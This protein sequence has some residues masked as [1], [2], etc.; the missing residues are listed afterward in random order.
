MVIADDSVFVFPL[1]LATSLVKFQWLVQILDGVAATTPE[2]VTESFDLNEVGAE[3]EDEL[4][5]PEYDD[6]RQ[7]LNAALAKR[8]SRN[9][10]LDHR[11]YHTAGA[12]E[13]IKVKISLST[14][15]ICNAFNPL[16]QSHF[17]YPAETRCQEQQHP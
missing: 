9:E 11:R 1:L 3:L 8:L 6:H 12:I 7:V 13:D 2:I 15:V 17:R 14:I 16:I 10:R 5:D 4:V